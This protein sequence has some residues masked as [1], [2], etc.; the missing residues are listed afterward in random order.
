MLVVKLFSFGSKHVKDPKQHFE[1]NHVVNVSDVFNPH[2]KFWNKDGRDFDVAQEV[3]GDN[4]AW[5]HIFQT[6][7]LIGFALENNVPK[8]TIAVGCFGGRHRSV[9]IVEALRDTISK[10]FD[11]TIQKAHVEVKVEHYNIKKKNKNNLEW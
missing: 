6:I 5:A 11:S 2:F 3:L 1:A 8:L 7:G 9:A 10:C 4:R